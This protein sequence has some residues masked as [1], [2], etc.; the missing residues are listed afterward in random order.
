M[1]G[2]FKKKAPQEPPPEAAAPIL[3]KPA[4]GHQKFAVALFRE[5]KKTG[6]GNLFF[7]PYSIATALTMVQAGASGRARE[8]IE[9]ALGHAGAGDQ[10]IDLAGTLS[11]ELASRSEP[12]A[13]E[14]SL[15]SHAEGATPDSFGC[16]LSPANAIWHQTGYP[17]RGSFV[18]ALK[19]RLGAE[20]RDVD[21]ATAPEQAVRAVNDWV[22]KATGDKIRD[23]LAPGGLHPMTRV[24][25]AN[26]IYFKAR[27][28][29]Q[30][31]EGATHPQAFRLLN[32][33]VVQVPM[34]HQGGFFSSARDPE[35]HA[36][37]LT[38]SGGQIAMIVLLP[39]AGRF[40]KVSKELDA[41]RLEGLIAA[42]EPRQTHLSL[43]RFRV[44][45]SFMLAAP[46]R[47]LWVIR[48]FER[49]DFSRISPE[50]GF[51]LS[52]V[53]HKTF[54]DVDE[55][56]TEAAA[57]TM[58]MLAGSAAPRS[59]VQFHVDRPFLFMIRDLP[60]GTPLFLGRVVDPRSP[61]VR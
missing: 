49:G 23:L 13:F 30:F 42:M 33:T 41:A 31:Q 7:S 10:L 59:L 36:L 9:A 39:E 20:V 11:R 29:E 15:A 19:S 18:E 16:R 45:S 43:P 28:Q 57:V 3:P 61:S 2:F 25:L 4:S 40:Q 27:W 53:L 17:I 60:T 6:D 34:M 46:L 5:L 54:V 56:G 8:E 48:A 22:A 51:F 38:Y 58:P 21:F 44:E 47:A 37:Q 50:P 32:D 52:E 1:F 55:K 26:A 35:I 14:K 12:T 24:L